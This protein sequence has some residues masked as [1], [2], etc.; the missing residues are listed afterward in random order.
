M[1]AIYFDLDQTIADLAGVPNW[2]G[3]LRAGLDAGAILESRYDD[4]GQVVIGALVGGL[5]GR[6]INAF[7]FAIV[8]FA[9]ARYMFGIL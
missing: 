7:I 5:I 9:V 1:Q 6:T 3:K 4:A 2:Q 8:F